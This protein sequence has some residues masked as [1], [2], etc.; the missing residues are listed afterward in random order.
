MTNRH[1]RINKS[2]LHNRMKR[3]GYRWFCWRWWEV[4]RFSKFLVRTGHDV[5]VWHSDYEEAK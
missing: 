5:P 4:W 2:R 1:R 3:A